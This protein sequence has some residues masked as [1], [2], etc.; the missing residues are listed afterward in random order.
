MVWNPAFDVDPA[1]RGQSILVFRKVW[2]QIAPGMNAR[3]S[4]ALR[5]VDDAAAIAQF[6]AEYEKDWSRRA[7][8]SRL[9]VIVIR[10]S[11]WVG[12]EYAWRRAAAMMQA[13]YRSGGD[14]RR[15]Y[16]ILPI[17]VPDAG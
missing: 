5:D 16:F 14:T 3:R 1:L 10:D 4:I 17:E 7:T 11:L 9:S 8:A 15:K 6:M 2:N 13:G 12:D